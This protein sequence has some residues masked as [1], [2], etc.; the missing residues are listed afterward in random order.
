[1]MGGGPRG[2]TCGRGHDQDRERERPEQQFH[3]VGDG[4]A[5]DEQIRGPGERARQERPADDPADIAML[6][7]V[8]AQEEERIEEQEREHGPDQRGQHLDDVVGGRVVA[9]AD[10]R[11]VAQRVEER[12]REQAQAREGST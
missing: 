9:S 8:V 12:D 1:M 6:D 3:P 10:A 2:E 11:Q 7:E 4:P 5:V